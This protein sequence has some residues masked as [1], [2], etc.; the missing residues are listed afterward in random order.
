VLNDGVN[1]SYGKYFSASGILVSYV[2]GHSRQ[3]LSWRNF[4]L[5]IFSYGEQKNRNVYANAR[6]RNSDMNNLSEGVPE[7]RLTLCAFVLWYFVNQN[8]IS[9]EVS[10]QSFDKRKILLQT[11]DGTKTAERFK[12]L[13]GSKRTCI[14]RRLRLWNETNAQG[15]I[16][17][18][19]W[20]WF[21]M[22]SI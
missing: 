11:P 7:L 15:Q 21:F 9:R 5:L 12:K 1:F 13:R 6:S 3:F 8:S 4:S 18:T 2:G 10:A 19:F 14:I 16:C 22:N 20:Q 17:T